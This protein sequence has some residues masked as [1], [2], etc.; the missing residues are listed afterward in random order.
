MS[1]LLD[2]KFNTFNNILSRYTKKIRYFKILKKF[3]YYEMI[4]SFLPSLC[5][6]QTLSYTFPCSFSLIVVTRVCVCLSV[7]LSECFLKYI[8]TTCS[9]HIM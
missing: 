6:F 2:K 4:T 8:N 3:F 5:S 1:L 9:C 7:F